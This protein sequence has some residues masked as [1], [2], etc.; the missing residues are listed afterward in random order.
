MHTAKIMKRLQ[1]ALIQQG[2]I[3]NINTIEFYSADQKRMITKY[4]VN[5]KVKRI[6]KKGNEVY[7]NETVIENCSQIKI[8]QELAKRL[9]DIRQVGT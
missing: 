9:N 2:D 1:R 6:D 8:V 7:K 3:L 5:Q 4:I